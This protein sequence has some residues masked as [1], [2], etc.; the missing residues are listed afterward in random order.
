MN[1]KKTTCAEL[2]TKLFPTTIAKFF[3]RSFDDTTWGRVV[4]LLENVRGTYLSS[5]SSM[6][7]WM[8][9][10]TRG[11]MR[12][13]L[14]DTKFIVGYPSHLF[15][16]TSPKMS[17]LVNVTLSPSPSDFLQNLETLLPLIIQ[18]RGEGEEHS[19]FLEQVGNV[20]STNFGFSLYKKGE[21]FVPA[22]FLKPPFFNVNNADLF[23]LAGLGYF[24]ANGL[25]QSLFSNFLGGS[26]LTF[27]PLI[28]F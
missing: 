5:L 17:A 3:V 15:N 23:N 19:K 22:G 28:F 10:E 20:S 25:T 2:T 1:G 21:L 26:K 13:G 24:T 18:Y 7:S 8:D 9:E 16:K 6:S 12:E 4:N 27:N 14:K 11:E